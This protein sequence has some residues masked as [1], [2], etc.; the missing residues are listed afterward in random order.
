MD[1]LSFT[2]ASRPI[3]VVYVG[4]HIDDKTHFA[5]KGSKY[6]VPRDTVSA[7][8][9]RSAVKGMSLQ[10]AEYI[11]NSQL[12]IFVAPEAIDGYY[13]WRKGINAGLPLIEFLDKL[14]QD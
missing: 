6:E 13:L 11:K 8:S 14:L 5:L 1:L 10:Y 3:N 2:G 9:I 12:Y 4:P 7:D